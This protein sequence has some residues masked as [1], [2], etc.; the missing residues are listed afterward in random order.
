MKTRN[1]TGKRSKLEV[2][3][4]Y[5]SHVIGFSKTGALVF[6][7]IHSWV[8]SVHLES[9]SGASF[10]Y[11]RHFFVPYDWFSGIRICDIVCAMANDDVVFARNDGIAVIKDG[12]EYV[13]IVD[14]Q[15]QNLE[16]EANIGLEEGSLGDS[17]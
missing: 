14:V 8:C 10:S 4:K 5:M 1:H 16:G 3:A 2:I 11:L 6:L 15:E 9:T 12:M 7:D 13:E 17:R